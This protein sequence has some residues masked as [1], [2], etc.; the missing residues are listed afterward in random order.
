[1]Q[2]A[3]FER[4][5]LMK[6]INYYKVLGVSRISSSSDIKRAYYRLARRYHPDK[7]DGSK[8]VLDKFILINQA[9]NILGNLENRLKYNIE[10]DKHE[11]GELES[12]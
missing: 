2:F 7:S 5:I 12:I 10:L 1:M 11:T 4:Q 6:F 8:K 3:Y 9:Y